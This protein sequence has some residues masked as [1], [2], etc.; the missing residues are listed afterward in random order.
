M[1]RFDPFP[2]RLDCSGI[3]PMSVI[4]YRDICGDRSVLKKVLKPGRGPETPPLHARVQVLYVGTFPE[5]GEVFD[6][7]NTL[8]APFAFELAPGVVI[9]GYAS[10]AC[11][12][13]C[14][15]TPLIPTPQW[16]QSNYDY[17]GFF[18]GFKLSVTGVVVVF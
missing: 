12:L 13:V 18:P 9:P 3:A 16:I 5:T 14:C 8:G 11:H 2:V 15:G 6:K 17:S 4:D 1:R 10:S 7:S